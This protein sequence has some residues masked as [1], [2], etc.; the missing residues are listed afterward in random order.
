MSSINS[1]ALYYI[2]F[3]E[4]A[5]LSPARLRQAIG[6]E[7][8]VRIINNDETDTQ[9]YITLHKPTKT[10]I[11]G[12]RGS[13]QFKDW[14]NDFNAFHMDYPYGNKNTKIRVHRGIMGCW[15]SVREQTLEIVQQYLNNNRFDP[16]NDVVVLGHSLGGALA[17]LCAVDIEYN[18]SNFF[19]G[20]RDLFGYSSGN[21]AVF[22]RAG[23]KSFNKRVP[24]FY[25]TYMRTDWVPK[26]PPKWFGGRLNG[27]FHHCGV[28]NPIGPK[29]RFYGLKV[30]WRA[31]H[32]PSKLAANLTNHAISL[33]RK[34]LVK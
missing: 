9:G 24:Y 29:Q 10:L 11:V 26:L 32:N 22:N 31:V 16:V 14:L 34:W 18:L 27:G 17:T 25:R 23:A 30:W 13:Q 21:P 33:Y 12:W 4:M 5:R 15:L 20:Q 8:V 7:N 28:G 3:A 19:G 2:D 1:D 6:H